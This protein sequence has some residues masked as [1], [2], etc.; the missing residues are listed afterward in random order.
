MRLDEGSKGKQRMKMEVRAS[1]AEGRPRMTW[2]VNI[3]HD[4]NKC[5]LAEEEDDQDGRRW[6]S[7]SPGSIKGMLL[8]EQGHFCAW[9]YILNAL[10]HM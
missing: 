2:M 5:G 4:M 3:R 1:R 10:L 6:R 9:N 8:E 7:S